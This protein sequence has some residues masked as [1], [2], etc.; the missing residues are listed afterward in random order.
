MMAGHAAFGEAHA[1]PEEVYA[2]VLSPS[3]VPSIPAFL[4]KA[5]KDLIKG[6]L[7][8]DPT[9]RLCSAAAVKAHPFFA[10]VDWD[11]VKDKR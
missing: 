1:R 4:P 6:L 11:A 7:Q 10:K 8:R 3:G 9:K 2:R 5:A